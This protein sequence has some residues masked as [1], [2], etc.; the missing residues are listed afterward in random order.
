MRTCARD[1]CHMQP[2]DIIYGN[3]LE[4]RFRRKGTLGCGDAVCDF[5]LS[6]A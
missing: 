1:G 4:L 3:L 5:D 2:N 6:L